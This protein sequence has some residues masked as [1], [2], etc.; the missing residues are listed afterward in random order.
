MTAL[1]LASVVCV[2]FGS[3]LLAVFGAAPPDPSGGSGVF[4][5]I[6]PPWGKGAP[7]LVR[8]AGGR[9]VGPVSAPFGTLAAFD[10]PAPG[11]RLRRLGAWAT[12]DAGVLA[13]LCGPRS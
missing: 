9:L 8:L 7:A 10:D 3:G 13:A 12:R 4:L 6:A 1:L 2:L 11:A 5:V